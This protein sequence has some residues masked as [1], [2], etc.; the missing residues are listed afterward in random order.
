MVGA[1]GGS[2]LGVSRRVYKKNRVMLASGG[3]NNGNQ[4]KERQRIQNLLCTL[5]LFGIVLN[6]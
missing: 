2:V 6:L 1:I 5:V 3:E 4:G